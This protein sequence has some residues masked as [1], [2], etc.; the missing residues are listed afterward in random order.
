MHNMWWSRE[1]AASE[2]ALEFFDFWIVLRCRK[3]LLVCEIFQIWRIGE[4]QLYSEIE[5]QFDFK[6]FWKLFQ[7]SFTTSSIGKADEPRQLIK[8]T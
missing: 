2:I 8:P 4:T 1:T 6:R 7:M 5:F 3:E